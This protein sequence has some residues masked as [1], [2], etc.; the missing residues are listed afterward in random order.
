MGYAHAK[1]EI[2]DTRAGI[3]F[4]MAIHTMSA[5][6]VFFKQFL[7]VMF[8]QHLLSSV[9][10]PEMGVESKMGGNIFCP[11][12]GRCQKNP[13]FPVLSGIHKNSRESLNF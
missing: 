5:V 11:I 2:W 7:R 9:I 1:S 10:I 13:T 12:R 8:F 4:A 6:T 3:P